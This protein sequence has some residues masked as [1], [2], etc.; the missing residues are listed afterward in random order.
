[1]CYFLGKYSPFPG[2]LSMAKLLTWQPLPLCYL[3]SSPRFWETRDQ[4]FPGSL[5]LSLRG[6]SRREPW[7]RGWVPISKLNLVPKQIV[8]NLAGVLRSR[9]KAISGS[10]EDCT[11]I[12]IFKHWQLNSQKYLDLTRTWH[13]QALHFQSSRNPAKVI[14]INEKEATIFINQTTSIVEANGGE[15][16]FECTALSVR[17]G[18]QNETISN[19]TENTERTTN[20]IQKSRSECSWLPHLRWKSKIRSLEM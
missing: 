7:E 11:T 2:G 18:V 14:N 3:L 16:N 9:F 4:R 20:P 8:A 13:T 19:V 17:Q 5:S 15:V 6:T 12:F 10:L 1:M